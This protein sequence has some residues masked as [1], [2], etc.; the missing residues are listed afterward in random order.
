[1][2]WYWVTGIVAL[3]VGIVAGFYIAVQYMKRQMAN[4]TMSDEDIQAMARSMGRNLNQK[5][6]ARISRQMKNVNAKA[7]ANQSKKKK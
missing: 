5:Q 2:V 6:L 1:M 7:L 4:M 3:L